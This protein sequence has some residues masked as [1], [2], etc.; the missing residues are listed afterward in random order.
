MISSKHFF[1]NTSNYEDKSIL[2]DAILTKQSKKF[3]R[4]IE[5]IQLDGWDI[6]QIIQFLSYMPD[7]FTSSKV[8]P[9]KNE[10]FSYKISINESIHIFDIYVTRGI[11]KQKVLLV[12]FTDWIRFDERK[13]LFWVNIQDFSLNKNAFHPLI[14]FGRFFAHAKQA[15]SPI[16][17]N[18]FLPL[19]KKPKE[20][21]NN[22]D[23]KNLLKSLPGY[24]ELVEQPDT[25]TGFQTS[26][27]Y[28]LQRLTW[29]C[30]WAISRI[31]H[32]QYFE[33]DASF[34]AT[35]PYCYC[36]VNSILNNESIIICIT[37]GTTESSELYEA[38]Y[39]ALENSGID[40]TILNKI[41]VLSD[42]G[43]GLYSFCLNRSL[44]QYICHRHILES[45]G[46]PIL[47]NWVKRLLECM[48][49]SEFDRVS[50]LIAEEIKIWTS[51][52]MDPK[53]I[54]DKIINVQTM[55]DKGNSSRFF[56]IQKWALWIRSEH[57]VAR[58]TNHAESMH[59]VFNIH[60]KLNQNLLTRIEGI[61]KDI[62]AHLTKQSTNHGRSIR[63]RYNSLQS[64]YVVTK[65]NQVEKE[66]ECGWNKYYSK[67]FGIRFPCIHEI[68][69]FK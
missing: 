59:H 14:I 17:R 20:K 33:L 46:H 52:I 47:R 29:V 21:K 62:I 44:I 41:P 30:A 61:T 36:C 25:K 63:E 56:A 50:V 10:D 13:Q 28:E 11:E 49:E 35:K 6:F 65:C 18:L 24:V 32:T 1:L 9:T 64:K 15:P 53:K 48:T 43:L 31:V 27:G 42:M 19:F 22:Q 40:C 4:K 8:E 23:I 3:H 55:L 26:T 57:S 54:P 39:K 45:F 68:S 51:Q 37:I 38:T 5:L 12:A 60:C 34:K 16:L 58:C 7:T 67:I 69:M 2:T 66:C